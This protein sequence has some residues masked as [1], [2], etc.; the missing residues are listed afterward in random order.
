MAAKSCATHFRSIAVVKRVFD[1]Q[2]L[3]HLD[4]NLTDLSELLKSPAHLPHQQPHQEVVSTEVVGQRIVQLKICSR[5]QSA[6]IT[7]CRERAEYKTAPHLDQSIVKCVSF[8]LEPLNSA[9]SK[10]HGQIKRDIVLMVANHPQELKLELI[11]SL[12]GIQEERH[13]IWL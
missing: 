2:P 8:T 12:V 11:Q 10:G 7:G 4:G 6:E 13:F 5:H 1:H 9:F 3:E